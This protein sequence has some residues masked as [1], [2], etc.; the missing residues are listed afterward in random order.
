MDDTMNPLGLEQLIFSIFSEYTRSGSIFNIANNYFYRPSSK[1]RINF[2]GKYLDLPIGVAA[3]PHTQLSQNI[4]S[5]F[6]TGARFI[7][8]KTVQDND[9][10]Q[11]DKPCI[12]A[13]DEGYNVE[14]STELKID[15]ALE[16]Y[17][18]SFLVILVLQDILDLKV[19][20]KEK[21]DILGDGFIFVSSIGYSFEGIRSEKVNRFINE[22]SGKG[23]K[24]KEITSKLIEI[25]NQPFCQK[26]ARSLGKRFPFPILEK[27][28]TDSYPI[29][30]I[31]TL[32]TMHGTKPEEIETIIRYLLVEKKLNTILKVNPTLLGYQK[33]KSLLHGH[34]FG[35]IKLSEESF[36]KD[37]YIEKAFEIV[38]RALTKADERKLH[39]GIKVSNTLPTIN[40]TNM[41]G[42]MAYLSGRAL[43][44][45]SLEVAE[46]FRKKFKNLVISFSA[47][48]NQKNIKEI[49]TNGIYPVTIVTD[50]LKPGGYHRL[51]NI[52]K[53][54]DFTISLKH[55]KFNASEIATGEQYQKLLGHPFYPLE[56]KVIKTKI[57]MF[58]CFLAPCIQSCPINQDVPLYLRFIEKKDY[59]NAIKVIFS[60]N[61]LPFITSKICTHFCMYNCTRKFYDN[62]IEIRN[63]KLLATKKGYNYLRE[64]IN[65]EKKNIK[66]NNIKVA[67]VGSGPAGL[68]AAN[69]L[70]RTGFDVTIFE[71]EEEY[72]GLVTYAIPKFRIKKSEIEKDI[73]LLKLLNVTFENR[74]VDKISK[75]KDEGFEYI[76]V[77]TGAN[78]SKK[79][80]FEYSEGNLFDS[81]EFLKDF[82]N[83]KKIKLG[84]EI[85]VIG[86][87]NSAMDAAR[88][89]K[90]IYGVKD[91]TV[92]YR[93]TENELPADREEYEN[94]I[95]D[96]IC[97]RMLRQ[98]VSYKN[99]T[100][101]CEIMQLT[102]KDKDGRR[103]A[104]PTGKYELLKADSIIV[105]IGE[106]IDREWWTENN[107]DKIKDDQKIFII[108]DIL[109]G[110]S[111]IVE[112]ISDARKAV[113]IILR[114]NNVFEDIFS[115]ISPIDNVKVIDEKSFIDRGKVKYPLKE[116]YKRCL[117]C[118]LYCGRC[119]DVCPNRA[120]S[121]IPFSN[122]AL[123][124]YYQIIHIDYLCNEC[125][126]CETFCPYEGKPYKEKFTIFDSIERFNES[127][128]PG[129]F[130]A[131]FY[132]KEQ[133]IINLRKDD[134]QTIK[135]NAQ[136][137]N[138]L[139]RSN[140]NSIE[141]KFALHLINNYPEIF[142]DN[143]NFNE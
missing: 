109:H 7:E 114:E 17:I 98:P 18:N 94:A 79:L 25:L 30:Q 140:E 28:A 85:I 101:T 100:L 40:Q 66:K 46:L 118:N 136:R 135:I 37:L 57:P 56:K 9:N 112:A 60:K 62:S 128:N 26:F 87:G 77:A 41:K 105:A 19:Q 67:I 69:F 132:D 2:W 38:E 83:K 89:A 42:Q 34:G 137:I 27:I 106:E 11:V 8:L 129:I 123:K 45:I 90:R 5:S 32:S 76:I 120:N 97:F 117:E 52:A 49:L 141:L 23:K 82:N 71:K 80:E 20:F 36:A 104:V 122:E 72:G 95:A 92:V 44:P 47:G 116:D 96:G 103:K 21:S 13:A 139:F 68:S 142:K 10:I 65:E 86:G 93:R 119:V 125:G 124:D 14:W 12:Y 75:L 130:V 35:Y 15:Q 143:F 110:P 74:Y 126:N 111:S 88:A 113:D 121:A 33:V 6:L 4:I 63:Q 127:R 43:F 54:S 73:A 102:E 31:T 108:G 16:E 131:P 50:L 91:V 55:K 99:K 29:A 24:V 138:N 64:F 53:V 84:K 1:G 134:Q 22:L 59:R 70:A 107:L 78:K 39:F 3:G 58:D 48:A 81:I 51:N 133:I 61:P 115:N